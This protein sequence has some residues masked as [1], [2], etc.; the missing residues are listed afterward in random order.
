MF[1]VCLFVFAS[2][3]PNCARL[4]TGAL[5]VSIDQMTGSSANLS[6]GRRRGFAIWCFHVGEVINDESRVIGC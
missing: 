1:F 5:S 2:Q 3:D 4:P 6:E